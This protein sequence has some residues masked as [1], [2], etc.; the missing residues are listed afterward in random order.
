MI[1]SHHGFEFEW[2]MIRGDKL[3]IYR[4]TNKKFLRTRTLVRDSG[5]VPCHQRRPDRTRCA[6]KNM[7]ANRRLAWILIERCSL[8]LSH[9]DAR[10]NCKAVRQWNIGLGPIWIMKLW[11]SMWIETDRSGSGTITNYDTN[12]RQAGRGRYTIGIGNRHAWMDGEREWGREQLNGRR[13]WGRAAIDLIS[14]C[15]SRV[16]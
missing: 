12:Y 11:M 9:A 3:I 7:S 6:C 13:E 4:K 8:N 5:L 10:S 2:Q 15:L 14:L 1:S 16:L